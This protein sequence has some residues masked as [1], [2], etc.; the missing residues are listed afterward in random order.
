M[1]EEWNATENYTSYYVECQP[2]ECIY[3]YTARNGILYIV[4]TLIG[5]L[6]G[7]IT[8]LKL[9]VPRL[10]GFVGKLFIY[11]RTRTGKKKNHLDG[12]HDCVIVP[13]NCEAI[14]SYI[15][16]FV[17]QMMRGIKVLK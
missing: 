3:S 2:S 10:V 16:T 4:T 6:G 7:L 5:L 15:H 14:L 17:L 9:L 13:G 8:V 12:N 1:V 11:S